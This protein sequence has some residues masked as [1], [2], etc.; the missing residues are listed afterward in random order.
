MTS[1]N[2]FLIVVV[3]VLLLGP[4]LAMAQGNGS[5]GDNGKS[6]GQ[7]LVGTSCY[8]GQKAFEPS[9]GI[10]SNGT[11]F[12]ESATVVQ[13]GVLL[14]N[15]IQRIVRSWND[16]DAWQDVTL[17]LDLQETEQ[18]VPPQSNDPMVHVDE[19]TDRV[20]NLDMQ[21]L[22]C[23]W[24]SYSDD[25]GESWTVNPVA[26]G[27]PPVLDHPTI[28]TGPPADPVD[29]TVLSKTGYPNVV[30]LCVNRIADS[31]CARSLDGG[32]TFGPFFPL[33]FSGSCIGASLHHFGVTDDAGRV[34]LGQVNQC[35]GDPVVA[36]STD[37]AR[38]W[39]APVSVGSG[40]AFGH[41]VDVA[42]DD[43]GNVY[44]G[45]IDDDR[46]PRLAVSTDHGS[47]WSAPLDPAPDRLNTTS[48][49]SLEAGAEGRLALSYYG[50]NATNPGASNAPWGGLITVS[51]DALSGSPTFETTNV[52][53]SADPVARGACNGN[54]RCEPP[55]FG[56]SPG[57]FLD[58]QIDDKGRPWTS[59]VDVCNGSCINGTQKSGQRAFAGT[60]EDGPRL[61]G[62]NGQLPPLK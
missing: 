50:T 51:T 35:T 57:D 40:P 16:C 19:D 49:L 61:A 36:V 39:R 9:L 48:F 44:A 55:Q 43:A 32:Q 28:F 30:Y 37:D 1:W 33:A 23:N 12:M 54:N 18:S 11:I 29:E 3:A 27:Q 20:F 25:D 45:W 58:V 42:V 10:T 46:R 2:K 31:A 24:L 14:I 21:G 60:L 62:G 47:S 17:E 7:D 22:F 15:E 8:T 4:S 5:G 59:M 34:F 53:A 38:T 52:N 13:R 56:G 6:I 41:D 26:C